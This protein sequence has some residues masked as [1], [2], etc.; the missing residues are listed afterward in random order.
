MVSRSVCVALFSCVVSPVFAQ[1]GDPGIADPMQSNIPGILL[2]A[3]VDTH[4]LQ[5]R[6]TD[7]GAGD[8]R[9]PFL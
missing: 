2:P 8:I 4:G 9:R 7:R 6:V 5:L 3:L 1:E